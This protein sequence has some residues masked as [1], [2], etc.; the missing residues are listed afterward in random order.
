M[1]ILARMNIGGPAIHVTLVTEKLHA[2]DYESMLVSGTIDEGE[3]DMM[4]YAAQH[5]VRPLII[6]ELGRSLNPLRDLKTLWKLYRLI[7]QW[8]PHIVHTNT[9]KAGFVGRLAA[10]L[11][12][13]PVI[14]HTFHGHVFH[15]YFSP[16]MTQTFLWIERSA[17]R[18]S[19]TLITLTHS[20]RQELSEKYHIAPREHF[21][22]MPYGLDLDVF[23]RVP[24]KQGTFRKQWK[25]APEVPLVGIVARL[26]PVKNHALFLQ[27]AAKVIQT[28]PNAHFMI[29]GDGELRAEVEAQIETLGLRKSVTVTGWT[30]DMAAVY[31]DL[32][33]K[34]ISSSNEGTPLTFIEALAA[35]CPVVGTDV[36]GVAEFLEQGRFGKVTPPGDAAAL[37]AAIIDTL[38]HPP[39][40]PAIRA[41]IIERYGIERLARDLDTLYRALLSKKLHLQ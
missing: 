29:I 22:I 11:A 16:F 18:L 1:N 5:G 9:A 40:M 31:A 21:T 17:A 15:G 4:Y 28:I 10:W 8:K 30:R 13:A 32:D 2:P 19:D 41:T 26:V 7:R 27:A 12:G 24:R 6:P 37:A 35:G 39:D 33:V 25:I 34:V 38:Q 36:G 3:G 14:V 23:A 20:L